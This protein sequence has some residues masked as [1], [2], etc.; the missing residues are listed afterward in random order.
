VHLGWPIALAAINLLV[1][2]AAMATAMSP[3][4][5]QVASG[6]GPTYASS[7]SALVSTGTLLFAVLA[8][9]TAGGLYLSFAEDDIAQSVTGITWA[10]GLDAILLAVATACAV[11]VWQ[12]SRQPT[13]N[14]GS[15]P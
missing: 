9:S 7:I 12:V 13:P 10:F 11:R 4:I 8:V 14:D 6:A 1:C 3:L 2:G 5:N 15:T